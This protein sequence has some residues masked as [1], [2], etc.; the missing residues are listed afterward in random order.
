MSLRILLLFVVPPMFLEVLMPLDPA[1]TW[2]DLGKLKDGCR[3]R[4]L[5]DAETKPCLD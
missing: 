3:I 1:W 5:Y 4:A 2:N